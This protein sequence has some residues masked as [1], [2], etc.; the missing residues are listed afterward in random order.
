MDAIPTAFSQGTLP[1]AKPGMISEK[2]SVSESPRATQNN[3][4][5]VR[6]PEETEGFTKAGPSDPGAWLGA[7]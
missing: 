2:I 6:H 1:Q 3:L 7:S 4:K 5:P